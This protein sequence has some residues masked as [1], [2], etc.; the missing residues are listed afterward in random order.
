MMEGR[1]WLSF[2]VGLM[3]TAFGAIPLLSNFIPSLQAIN[4]MDKAVSIF[5]YVVAVMGFYLMVN[6]IIEITN[7]NAVGGT[8]LLIAILFMAI[9]VLQVLFKFG[10]G[11]G[12]FELGFIKH[13]LYYIIFLVE[14]LFLM[15]AAFA[16]EL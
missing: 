4:F 3:L 12:W 9:G 7:S 16:M 15:I 13:T 14:G 11:P 1:D 5:A 2:F 8:S 10:V 6:S